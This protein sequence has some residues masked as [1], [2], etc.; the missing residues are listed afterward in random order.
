MHLCGMLLFFANRSRLPKAVLVRCQRSSVA[1][2]KVFRDSSIKVT[3]R[4]LCMRREIAG[5]SVVGTQ[6]LLPLRQRG[7][8]P[9]L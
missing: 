4:V 1:I 3:G 8:H 2:F 9:L 7:L 5:D 6:L